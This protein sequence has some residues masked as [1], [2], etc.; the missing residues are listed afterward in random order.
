MSNP[1]SG[2]AQFAVSASGTLVYLPSRSTIDRVPIH[3]MNHQGKTTPLRAAPAVWSSPLF[4]RDGRRLAVTIS[5]GQPS[6]IWVY[7]WARD[8]LTRLTFDPGD[9][10]KPVWTPDGLRIVFASRRADKSTANLYWQRADGTGEAQRLTES[11]SLQFPASWHPSG[12]FLAFSESQT[13]YDLMILPMEGD[14]V[15]GWRPGKPT[16]FLHSPF[17]KVEP[18]FSPDGRWIAYQSNESGR[19]EVYVRPFPGP[20][21]KWQISTGGGVTPTWSRT[22]RELFY[23]TLTGQIMVAPFTVE[24]DSFRAEKPRLWSEAQFTQRGPLLRSFD[25]HPDGERFALQPAEQTQAAAKQDKVI[26]VFNFF[27]ELRRLAPVTRR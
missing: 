17:D 22:K 5:D 10:M 3:W 15:S 4:D 7:E 20:G 16:V 1:T 6:H 12:K 26:F 11:K 13:T 27:D 8:V 14:E 23:G 24:G 9:D 19:A 2:G 25:L 21:G 18:M